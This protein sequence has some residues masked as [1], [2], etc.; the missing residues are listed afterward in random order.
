[1]DSSKYKKWDYFVEKLVNNPNYIL[2]I[3]NF[4]NNNNYANKRRLN[5][6]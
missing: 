5:N 1:M 3:H 6:N 2:V 4:K